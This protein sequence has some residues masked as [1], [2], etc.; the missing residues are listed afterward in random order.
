MEKCL[1]EWED[2]SVD[3]NNA[4]W[5]GARLWRDRLEAVQVGEDRA[6]NKAH[7]LGRSIL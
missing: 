3:E 7:D 1:P 4:S 6:V 5:R 2:A